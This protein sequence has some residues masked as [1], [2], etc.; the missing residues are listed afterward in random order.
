MEPAPAKLGFDHFSVGC[1]FWGAAQIEAEQLNS[2]T[3]NRTFPKLLKIS[4]MERIPY[5]MVYL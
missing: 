3:V 5:A 1:I 4:L 2:D